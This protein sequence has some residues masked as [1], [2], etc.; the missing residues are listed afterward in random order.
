MCL[1]Q[2]KI[3]L[4]K[5]LR[6]KTSR[7]PSD[8]WF[9]RDHKANAYS[10]AKTEKCRNYAVLGRF[11]FVGFAY[12]DFALF[13]VMFEGKAEGI[14]LCDNLFKQLAAQIPYLHHILFGLVDKV[15]DRV[16]TC[17]LQAVEA[18]DR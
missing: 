13:V 9:E 1:A 10:R 2:T 12:S 4:F 11:G 7:I 3:R 6:P 8:F 14:Q 16:Y 15:F 18:A 17:A 5:I